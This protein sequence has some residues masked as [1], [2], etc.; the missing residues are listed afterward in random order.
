MM[1]LGE[2]E[3]QNQVAFQSKV[4]QVNSADGISLFML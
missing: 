1:L 2:R 4:F 3:L